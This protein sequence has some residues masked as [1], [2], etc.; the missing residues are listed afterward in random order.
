[1]RAITLKPISDLQQSIE[2]VL[3]QVIPKLEELLL[4][5]EIYHI[6]ATAILGAVSKGDIDLLL[7]VSSKDFPSAL[8]ILKKL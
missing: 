4:F 6:G 5:S 1:M 7:R 2:E 3:G 8:Q